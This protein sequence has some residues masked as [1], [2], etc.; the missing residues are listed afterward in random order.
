MSRVKRWHDVKP[1]IIDERVTVVLTPA[2]RDLI[3]RALEDRH[4]RVAGWVVPD[5]REERSRTRE[6]A[7]GSTLGGERAPRTGKEATE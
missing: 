3:V 6:E 7:Q 1:A 4:R 2:Q 5:A